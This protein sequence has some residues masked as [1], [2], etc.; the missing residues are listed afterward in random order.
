MRPNE[1]GYTSEEVRD[2]Q[3]V[4]NAETGRTVY[5]HVIARIKQTLPRE[6][7]GMDDS[8]ITTAILSVKDS[9]LGQN[10]APGSDHQIGSHPAPGQTPS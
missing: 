9:D 7:G 8:S 10:V 5:P 4:L 2:L 6:L 1:H 3:Y